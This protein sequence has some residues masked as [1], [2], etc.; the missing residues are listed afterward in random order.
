M[1][2][3][4][5]DI[6]TENENEQVLSLDDGSLVSVSCSLERNGSS[7]VF[8]TVARVVNDD[9][10][11]MHDP[12]GN[13]IVSSFYHTV[14]SSSVDNES[15]VRIAKDCIMAVIGEK[16]ETPWDIEF[17]KSVNIKSLIN[18]SKIIGPIDISNSL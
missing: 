14:P 16:T 8:Y 1:S 18:A 4:K 5:V 9:G 11:V 7:V 3:S 10:S 6:K 2:Y 15:S 13:D 17:L 12:L